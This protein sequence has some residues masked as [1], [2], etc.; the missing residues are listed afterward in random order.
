MASRRTILQ[1]PVVGI[2]Q[3][4]GHGRYYSCPSRMARGAWPV[5]TM[6]SLASFRGESEEMEVSE[7]LPLRRRS[8]ALI[9]AGALLGALRLGAEAREVR[10]G[11]FPAAPLVIVGDAKPTGLFIDLIEHFAGIL[12]WRIRY[13][14]GTWND[15]LALLGKGEIDLLPAVGYTDARA[16]IYD[17]SKVPVYIDSG[18]LF[19]SPRSIPHTVFELQGKRVAGVRGSIFTTGFTDYLRSFG[20]SC[21]LVPTDDN[22]QV[23]EAI[24]RGEV[25]AGV[26]IYSLGNELA[27]DFPV[28]ITPISFSPIALEF[29]VPRGKNLDLL[30]GID[31]LMASMAGDPQSFYSQS[32]RNWTNPPQPSRIPPWLWWGLLGLLLLGVWLGAWNILLKQQVS[33]KT[34]HLKLEIAERLAAEAR[35]TDSL[36]EKEILIRELY[37]RT[38]NTLQVVRSMIALQAADFPENR[39]LQH[40]VKN[41]EDRIRAIS[42]VHQMLYRSQDLS[43]IS[44]NAYLGELAA[45]ILRAYESDA[46]QVRL[47]LDI[48]DE[49]W[50]ID[51]VVAVGLVLNELM[52]NSLKYAF[53]GERRGE[54]SV[55]LRLRPEKGY[56]FRYSDNGIGLPDGFDVRNQSSLGLKLVHAIVEHQL[57]G[58][59]RFCRKEGIAWV[60]EI[61]RTGDDAT[62]EA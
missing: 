7:A 19:T 4:P 47:N 44:V 6:S 50:A 11:V 28:A 56:E 62:R 33:T 34:H 24:V 52:T 26:C 8:L 30:S 18:V 20:L 38:K 15:L 41:T 35:L 39:E 49:R 46:K 10:V 27:R 58:T 40:V 29:A 55:F 61:P 3:E 59:V 60:I 22:R 21:E 31:G 9:L 1:A 16:A 2:C 57:M 37:H 13:E 25:D 17:F 48:E 36:N 45:S 42:L 53:P 43:R 32:F 23:M 14:K 12:E 54:I 5:R 51:T